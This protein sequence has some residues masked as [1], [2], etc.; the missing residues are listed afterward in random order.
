MTAFSPQS[1]FLFY[2]QNPI[3]EPELHLCFYPRPNDGKNFAYKRRTDRRQFNQLHL[4]VQT[5]YIQSEN[6]ETSGK[7]DCEVSFVLL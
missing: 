7:I 6:V 3:P 4:I 1:Q 2:W 5:L